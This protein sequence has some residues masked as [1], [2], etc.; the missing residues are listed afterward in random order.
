MKKT[1]K[2]ELERIHSLTYGSTKSVTIVEGIFESSDDE[3]KADEVTG[4]VNDFFKS[5]SDVKDQGGLSQEERG[6]MEYKK[7]VETLQ[8]G[9][10]LLGYELPRF[11]VDGLFGPETASAVKKFNEDNKIL[12]ESIAYDAEGLIGKPGQGT[13][14]ASDWQSRNA[15]DVKM[16]VGSSVK[17][18]TNGT[19]T[20]VYSSGSGLKKS[21]NKKIYGD[22]IT[23]K[24]SDGPD[25]FYTH[26][27][28][29]VSAG[30]NVKV[31][32]EI[33][34]IMTL[35]GMPSHVHIG[36][37]SGNLSDYISNLPN[38]TGGGES[39]DNKVTASP[40]MIEV[41]IEKLKSLSLKDEDIKPHTNQMI[42]ADGSLGEK[43][44]GVE[45]AKY[46]ISKG[47]TP[48]HAAGIAGNIYVESGYKTGAIGDSGTSYGLVQ[49]HNERWDRL[50]EFC[51]KNNLD[52]SS[53]EGQLIYLD[54]ELKTREKKARTELMRTDTPSESAYAFAKYFERPA[55]I[56]PKRMEKAE[57]I[58]KQ[59]A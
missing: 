43:S 35:P 13:H 10:I 20:K 3:K 14:N 27:E 57:E 44:S 4:E 8:I 23:V 36:L 9:L 55:K 30:Q 41:M 48:E 2:E 54:W 22:Q 1:L 26:L 59:L 17:S 6:S 40:E 5:L 16:S 24:S 50:K 28:S 19:V 34:K 37:S 53:V 31:G 25:V 47:Y 33:G 32:D 29:S 15:W 42:T 39:S 7:G 51:E 18:I 56:S 49:W 38:A 58:Y 52:P 46:L 45:I 11:G 21:G 12:S